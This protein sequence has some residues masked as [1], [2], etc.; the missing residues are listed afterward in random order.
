MLF[1]NPGVTLPLE[2]PLWDVFKFPTTEFLGL[3]LAWL[4]FPSPPT[5]LEALATA[6][7]DSLFKFPGM[8]FALA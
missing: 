5:P 8:F 3:G 2:A 4:P 6:G 7:E 1:L